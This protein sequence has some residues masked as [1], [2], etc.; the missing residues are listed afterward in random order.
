MHP[1]KTFAESRVGILLIGVEGTL[2]GVA[3][4]KASV[5]VYR[6]AQEDM[7]YIFPCNRSYF[8]PSYR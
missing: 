6:A 3:L 1:M 2:K 8:F 5:S 4:S 7:P